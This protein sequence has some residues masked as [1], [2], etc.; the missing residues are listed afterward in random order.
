MGLRRAHPGDGAPDGLPRSATGRVPQWVLDD[1]EGR[2]PR[3]AVPWRQGGPSLLDPDLPDLPDLPV[4]GRPAPRGRLRRAS[5]ALVLAL[6]AVAV[7]ALVTGAVP[8]REGSVLAGLAAPPAAG[9][10]HPTPGREASEQP[11]GEPAPLLTT[12]DAYRFVTPGTGA[13]AVVGYDPCRPVHYV[14]RTD[15]APEQ[16]ARLV[17]EAIAR[18]SR[19]TGLVFVDDGPTPEAFAEERAVYQPDLY[20]DRWAP[21]L[22]VWATPEEDPGLAGPVAGMAGSAPLSLGGGPAVYV[23]GEVRLDAPQ[24]TEAL[25]LPG[26]EDAVRAV[27]QH[28]LG[29]VVGLDHVDDPHQLMY[30]ET[31]LGVVDFAAGDLTGLAQLG[32]GPCV[33]EL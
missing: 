18:V 32:R 14:T 3:H 24:L 10:D 30:P 33:P 2:T 29:H 31:R 11:L 6:G 13:Q 23:T 7:W 1:V 21:V 5:T 9:E 8:L 28:E 26:G 12:S 15:G 19:A 25:A 22:V 17:A 27:V 4:R 20:G 16:G